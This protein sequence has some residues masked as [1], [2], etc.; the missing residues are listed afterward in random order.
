MLDEVNEQNKILLEEVSKL[1]E[2]IEQIKNA[3]PKE[4]P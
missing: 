2:E 4:M 1:K 3:A